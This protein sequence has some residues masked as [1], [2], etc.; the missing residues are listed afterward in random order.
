L[1]QVRVIMAVA[2]GL[3]CSSTTVMTGAAKLKLLAALRLSNTALNER[4]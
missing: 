4:R 2:T 1:A 3:S